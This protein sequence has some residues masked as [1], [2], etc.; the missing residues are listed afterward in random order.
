MKTLILLL[1]IASPLSLNAE[2]LFE[3]GI[4]PGY[5]IGTSSQFS[6]V[7]GKGAAFLGLEGAF[8][9]NTEWVIGVAGSTMISDL[10][11]ETGH[12]PQSV[13]ELHLDYFGAKIGYISNPSWLIHWTIGGLIGGGR[14]K[15]VTPGDRKLPGIEYPSITDNFFVV[16][17]EFGAEVNLTDH[18]RLVG[19]VTYRWISFAGNN[20]GIDSFDLSGAGVKFSLHFGK[21]S[22]QSSKN[23]SSMK[24]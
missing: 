6:L 13:Q 23:K 3:K 11:I 9:A 4:E 10:E 2:S 17:P 24:W 14:T 21:M 22:P 8:V 7:D 12:E 18:L 16:E 20:L 19:V 5:F 1:I 15:F